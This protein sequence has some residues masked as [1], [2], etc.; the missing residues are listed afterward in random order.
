MFLDS[1]VSPALKILIQN[2]EGDS[3]TSAFFLVISQ[4][5]LLILLAYIIKLHSFQLEI[6]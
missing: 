2:N 6:N 4:G 3:C 1:I 5:C